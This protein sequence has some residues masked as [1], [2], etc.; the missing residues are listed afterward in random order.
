MSPIGGWR[1]LSNFAG[2]FHRQAFR[3][4][5]LGRGFPALWEF[6]EENSARS[7]SELRD[8]LQSARRKQSTH[9]SPWQGEAAQ[10]PCQARRQS[11]SPCRVE[12]GSSAQ[13]RRIR[14]TAPAPFPKQVLF[15]LCAC[16]R[17][18]GVVCC[19][20]T[21]QQTAG[22]AE[23]LRGLASLSLSRRSKRGA[24]E[25][26]SVELCLSFLFAI[27]KKWRF[28]LVKRRQERP[29]RCAR[30]PSPRVPF[31]PLPPRALRPLAKK[32]LSRSTTPAL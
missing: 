15:D 5:R 28:S 17:L 14:F 32:T 31:L 3:P 29:V 22:P 19:N 16:T 7:L 25:C 24:G 2:V 4:P 1:R 26:E 27:F 8:S 12:C 10:Q 18:K 6:P 9:S 11:Q 21:K 13:N 20:A 23:R 30:D